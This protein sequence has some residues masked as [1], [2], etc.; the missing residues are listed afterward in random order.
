MDLALT[1]S[2]AKVPPYYAL[3]QELREVIPAM[4]AGRMFGPDGRPLRRGT[5]S[6]RAARVLH[7]Y[8]LV[9]YDLS[10][11]ER[12]AEVALLGNAGDAKPTSF[13]RE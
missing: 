1:R 3:L 10:V 2:G 6:A 13:S 5:L 8:A 12:Y 9:Q 11:G 4:D 7:D